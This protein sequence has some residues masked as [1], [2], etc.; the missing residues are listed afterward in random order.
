MNG[1]RKCADPTV[2]ISRPIPFLDPILRNTRLEN[3]E[4]AVEPTNEEVTDHI[5]SRNSYHP[6]VE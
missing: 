1:Q 5:P 6:I 2:Q 3:G 4:K